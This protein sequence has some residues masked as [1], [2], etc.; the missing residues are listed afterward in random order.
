MM[1]FISS[2]GD[3]LGTIE[4][5]EFP[6]LERLSLVS[7]AKLPEAGVL[8]YRGEIRDKMKASLK[9][10]DDQ[11]PL[12]KAKVPLNILGFPF[13]SGIAA[14]DSKELCLNLSTFFESG[15]SLKIAYRPND[16]WN[17]FSLVVKTGIGHFGSP[18]SA[19]MTMSAEFNL[20]GR[21]NPSFFLHFRPNIGDFS[22]KKS[23]GSPIA[24]PSQP[25]VFITK[26]QSQPKDIE[27]DNEESTG[28]AETPL[29]NGIYIPENGIF[30]SKKINGFMPESTATNAID[31]LFSGV[32]MSAR[33]SLALR[34]RAILKVRWGVRFPADLKNAFTEDGIRNSTAEISLRKIPFLVMSKIAIEH[35]AEEDL[36]SKRGPAAN[37]VG[38]A[39]VAEACFMVKRQLEA[40]QSENGLLRKAIED[41][42]S[43][44]G[45][46]K[47]V[48]STGFQGSGK[49]SS[50][51]KKD[52]RN[53]TERN[54]SEVG[55]GSVGK[56]TDEDINEELKKALMG[57]TSPG[58]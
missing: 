29:G 50:P 46:G 12:F 32:E 34:N 7:E 52:R 14:G 43:E 22:I 58:I 16:S 45:T 21:G 55:V 19:P 28:C 17:P 41:L 5:S 57:S 42:R 56:M 49:M 9:F 35:V 23:A 26:I 25:S 4:C 48:S 15:P 44:I 20:V 10:R 37:L 24:L 18:I 3:H 33:T 6:S 11:K 54:S 30:S 8:E 1:D 31:S 2:L 36:K 13:Q 47:S 38:N 53:K 27:S 51:G 40:L 39:D